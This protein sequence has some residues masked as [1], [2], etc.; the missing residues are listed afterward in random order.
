MAAP[1]SSE[2]PLCRGR[3][4]LVQLIK[5]KSQR[6]TVQGWVCKQVGRK[7]GAGCCGEGRVRRLGGAQ[8]GSSKRG[9]EESLKALGC[10]PGRRCGSRSACTPA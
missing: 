3:G 7:H 6:V 2:A 4:E 5:R 8:P 10:P 9:W 1:A